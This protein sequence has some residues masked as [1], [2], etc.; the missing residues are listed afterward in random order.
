MGKEYGGYACRLRP[1]ERYAS[2]RWKRAATRNTRA[3]ARQNERRYHTARPA[4]RCCGKPPS[5][6]TLAACMYMRYAPAHAEKGS[7]LFSRAMFFIQNVI[8]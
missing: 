5:P 6:F 8:I 3:D 1:A 7:V 4:Q 2:A